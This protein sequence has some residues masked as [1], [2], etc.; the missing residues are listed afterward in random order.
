MRIDHRTS[1]QAPVDYVE[2]VNRAIDYIVH[3]LD[4]PLRLEHVAGV[5][6][7]SPFHFHRVF[8][9]L[10]GETLNQFVKRLRLER[11]LFL[12]AHDSQRP[13]T[14]VALSCG[15]SS[16]SDFSRNFRQRYGVPPSAL[17]LETFRNSKR[18]DIQT[19]TAAD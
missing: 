11:A 9:S 16:S 17:D 2:R 7:F 18:D 6:C 15:F 3:N 5:A 1:A 4:Q 13:L 14:E 10:V 19:L 12:M 8:R